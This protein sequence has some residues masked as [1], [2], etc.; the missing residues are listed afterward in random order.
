MSIEALAVVLNHSKARPLAKIVL[1]GIANHYGAND[2]EGA[3]PNQ[4]RLARYANITERSVRNA[5]NELMELGE[6][7][8][9]KHAGPGDSR[10]RPNRYFITLRCPEDC[11]GSLNHRPGRNQSRQEKHDIRQEQ[12]GIQTGTARSSD[13]N[14]RSAKPLENHYLTVGDDDV[15]KTKATRLAEDWWPDEDA[16][17]AM[18]KLYPHLDLELITEEFKDYWISLPGTRAKKL[19][20]TRTWQGRVRTEAGR[21]HGRKPQRKEIDLWEMTRN[22]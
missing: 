19:D 2:Y 13:R 18:A 14:E 5:I 12:P 17:Q 7:T 4:E 10:Y 8:S 9:E 15:Q 16:W 20:W 22:D 6:L 1:L 3:Y 21:A 11:D